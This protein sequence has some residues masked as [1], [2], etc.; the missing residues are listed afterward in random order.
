MVD[1]ST[2]GRLDDV[3]GGS[4]LTVSSSAEDPSVPRRLELSTPRPVIADFASPALLSPALLSR[5][6]AVS[7]G[8]AAFDSA[9]DW[10]AMTMKNTGRL[11]SMKCHIRFQNK[12]V[13]FSLNLG[14]AK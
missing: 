6:E 12:V 14:L 11:R 3:V 9:G 8:F 5:V 1:G 7:P 13:D 4:T 2:V 10:V